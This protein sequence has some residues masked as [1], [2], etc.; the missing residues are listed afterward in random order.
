MLRRVGSGQLPLGF[1]PP[2][3]AGCLSA[4][5]STD[6]TDTMSSEDQSSSSSSSSSSLVEFV[7][8]SVGDDIIPRSCRRVSSDDITQSHFTRRHVDVLIRPALSAWIATISSTTGQL[9]TYCVPILIL[10]FVVGAA[11]IGWLLLL[12]DLFCYEHESAKLVR[13]GEILRL[14]C[15]Q[16]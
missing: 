9:L 12:I 14:H 13:P 5:V 1:N 10:A 3:F 16:C 2:A 7:L 4:F 11:L 6:V 8:Y 15:S